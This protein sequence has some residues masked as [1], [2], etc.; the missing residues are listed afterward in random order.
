MHGREDAFQ[1]A[2]FSRPM[3]EHAKRAEP[4]SSGLGI[5]RRSERRK[6]AISRS[7]FNAYERRCQRRSVLD[8]ARARE[9]LTILT[10]AQVASCSSR[11]S[12][13]GREAMVAAGSRS[14]TATR[15]FCRRAIH[16][17]RN[18]MRAGSAVGIFATKDRRR[19]CGVGNVADHPRP[20]AA[21]QAPRADHPRLTRATFTFAALLVEPPDI[22]PAT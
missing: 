17:P 3:P 12:L 16:S 1:C 5:P 22:H 18:L 19:C 10:E 9:N 2:A 13:R 14:S 15:S 21:S 7:L 11:E 4:L 20:G 8:P 6:D